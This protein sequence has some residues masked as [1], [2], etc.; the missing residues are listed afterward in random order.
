MVIILWLKLH[1]L[2]KSLNITWLGPEE[3]SEALV[4]PGRMPCIELERQHA[5]GPPEPSKS[6]QVVG[7]HQEI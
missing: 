7:V 4:I 1:I 2:E 5:Q 3:V 6:Q